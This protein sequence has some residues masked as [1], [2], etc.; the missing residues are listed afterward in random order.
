MTDT[1]TK[2]LLDRIAEIV[3]ERDRYAAAIEGLADD[4]GDALETAE[5]LRALYREALRYIMER[6]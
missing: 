5:E 4:L 6:A 2:E 3:R 1:A